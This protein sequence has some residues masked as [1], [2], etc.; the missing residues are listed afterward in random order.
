MGNIL[1]SLMRFISSLV[2]YSPYE[3]EDSFLPYSFE[4]CAL[5]YEPVCLELKQCVR[6]EKTQEEELIEAVE[7]E[8][9]LRDEKLARMQCGKTPSEYFSD[10][11]I[12]GKSR[13]LSFLSETL[14]MLKNLRHFTFTAEIKFLEG[15]QDMAEKSLKSALIDLFRESRP[16]PETKKLILER[17]ELLK[18][19]RSQEKDESAYDLAVIHNPD[20]GTHV[21]GETRRYKEKLKAAGLRW[22]PRQQYWGL[23]N[24]VG[25]QPNFDRLFK[26]AM[27]LHGTGLQMKVEIA[28]QDQE[29]YKQAL[30]V[31][32]NE[33]S[34][35]ALCRAD[36]AREQSTQAYERSKYIADA[37]PM[38]Q[39]VLVGHHSEKRHRR[40][41]E[42]INRAM[43]QS[44]AASRKSEYLESK[45]E[46]YS[47]KADAL[48]KELD[49]EQQKQ[50]EE[51]LKKV[52]DLQEM[53]RKNL[54]KVSPV[55]ASCRK[56][57]EG[58]GK[59]SWS[60]YTITFHDE[61]MSWVRIHFQGEKVGIC[62]YRDMPQMITI[63]DAEKAYEF[64]EKFLKKYV[65]ENY[66]TVKVSNEKMA[67]R[68]D[69]DSYSI[70]D[71]EDQNNLPRAISYR[72]PKKALLK[73]FKWALSNYERI[74]GFSFGEVT[75][76][77]IKEA[78]AS[79]HRYCGMD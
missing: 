13:L 38:G 1:K 46:A 22:K 62:L 35:T 40:D 49:P 78:G 25:K 2:T 17:V 47:K 57:C 59:R 72:E 36:R 34:E 66:R 6:P 54:K 79:P 10:E 16:A 74:E 31:Y 14:T 70:E 56:D 76:C 50:K 11:T 48:A 43:G 61:R 39:P 45:A 20:M 27:K 53:I 63:S 15:R 41:I 29:E 64:L 71:K 52:A 58:K 73:T 8:R 60:F 69:I 77:A 4:A 3:P 5:E 30:V 12:A 44:V 32:L 18:A 21:E 28:D 26:V 75:S 23:L 19:S 33:K 68:F 9:Q 67:C 7:F 65:K 24:T 51:Q 55:V 42:K 37:I